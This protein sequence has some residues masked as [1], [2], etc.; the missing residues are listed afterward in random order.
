MVNKERMPLGF[1]EF[2]IGE[3]RHSCLPTNKN[4]GIGTSRRRNSQTAPVLL[5]VPGVPAFNA[6]YDILEG[7]PTHELLCWP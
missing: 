6:E 7:P 2:S 3:G 5:L 1:V 4:I